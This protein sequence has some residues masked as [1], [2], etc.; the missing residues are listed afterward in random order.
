MRKVNK[1]GQSPRI[2]QKKNSKGQFFLIAAIIIAGIL[3]GIAY[4]I[5]YST[6]TVSH[7]AE[8]VA[9]E[10]RIEAEYV[11]DYELNNPVTPIDEFEDFSAEY[12][13][14]AED[15]D[16]YFIVVDLDNG[17]QD[18][19]M[20]NENLKVDL[21]S[22][23]HVGSGEIQFN[24]DKPYTFPLEEGKNF[25]SVVIYDKGGERYVYTG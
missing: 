14:Y 20:Y 11:L 22:D 9:D 17:V 10:L 18:A 4:M 2:F 5:N 7:E 8:E 12:S 13:A 23:L 24:I 6:K 15:K 25:Y 21:G 1:K 16:I 19:Y 3:I